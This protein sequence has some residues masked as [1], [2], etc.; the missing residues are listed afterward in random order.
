MRLSRYGYSN[1]NKQQMNVFSGTR[2]L[3]KNVCVPQRAVYKPFKKAG[4][5]TWVGIFAAFVASGLLHDYCWTVMFYYNT[6]A[7]PSSCYTGEDDGECFRPIFGKQTAFF[8]WCGVTMLL[9]RPVGRLAPVRW[10]AKNLPLVVVSLLNVLT[11]VPLA[12]WYTGDW[13][14][15]GFLNAYSMGI[16]RIRYVN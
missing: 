13:I 16:F 1:G 2:R 9:E 5:S 7:D 10:M 12:H 15:G 8:A 3:T 11:A 4:Y 14:Q 6:K